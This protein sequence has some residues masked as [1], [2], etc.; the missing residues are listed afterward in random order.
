MDRLEHDGHQRWPGVELI[1]L[2]EV[3]GCQ[4]IGSAQYAAVGLARSV[5]TSN[6]SEMMQV[7]KPPHVSVQTSAWCNC[8]T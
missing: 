5:R 6:Y 4:T 2:L 8:D 3:C 1:N 7:S